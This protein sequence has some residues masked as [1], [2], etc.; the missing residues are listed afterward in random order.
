M[1]S[2]EIDI[3]TGVEAEAEEDLLDEVLSVIEVV[4]IQVNGTNIRQQRANPARLRNIH[5]GDPDIR[6]EAH[7]IEATIR[8][9]TATHVLKSDT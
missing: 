8:R 7:G 9:Y 6:T 5:L 2:Q 4:I 3:I 1:S